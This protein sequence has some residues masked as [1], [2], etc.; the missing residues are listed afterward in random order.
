MLNPL[1]RNDKFVRFNN[2]Y[3][4]ITTARLSAVCISFA[5]IACCS[6]EMVLG[7]VP[8]CGQQH[9]NCERSIH[10][11]YPL[12][13]CKLRS[14]SNPTN[15]NVKQQIRGTDDQYAPDSNSSISVTIQD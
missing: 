14:S 13:F 12:F 10:L 8:L 15:K 7:Q 1:H 11:V 3:T 4:K 9:A 2:K 6:S 5:K